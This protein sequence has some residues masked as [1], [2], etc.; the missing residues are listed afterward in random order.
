[1]VKKFILVSLLSGA[2]L[3]GDGLS[4]TIGNPIAVES[5][6]TKVFALFAARINGCADVSKAQLTATGHG[7]EENT[8]KSVDARP[9]AAPTPGV[10]LI[11]RQWLPGSKWVV[12]VSVTCGNETTGAIVPVTDTGFVRE[13]TQMLSHAPSPAEIDAA[14]KAQ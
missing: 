9:M 14:L 11:G 2:G 13:R 8:R 4:L 12:A 6:T 1:M 5:K 3:W 10:Y 7:T